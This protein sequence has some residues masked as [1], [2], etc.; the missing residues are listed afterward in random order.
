MRVEDCIVSVERRSLG[1]CID[2]AFVFARQFALPLL[3]V[4]LC[5]A[6]PSTL[7]VWFVTDSM[8][9][10]VLVPSVIIFAFFQTLCS[11]A[12]V[13][14][15]GPQV[16]GVPISTKAAL[17]GLFSR[18]IAYTFLGMLAR[19]TGFCV[20]IPLL[21]VFAWCGHLPEVM[22]LERTPLNQVTQRL[23][24]LGKGGGYSRNL[25][26]L[27][28]LAVFWA[29][30]AFGVF[31]AL[32]VVFS[33]AFNSPIFEGTIA[34]GPDWGAAFVSKLIDDPTLNVFVQISFWIVMPVIRLAWFFCYLDQ[35]IRNECWDLELQ[36]RVESSRLEEQMA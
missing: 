23:S 4:T 30:C 32:D 33:L 31:R 19:L 14:T 29:I 25:G 6:V 17:K 11:G 7:F 10:D 1:G 15:V 12:L 13:A 27:I 21:F 5:F 3:S 20:L 16:F 24:W 22:F 28:T 8:R 35:R 36:Y 9:H 34:A 26:R 18:L 2:L